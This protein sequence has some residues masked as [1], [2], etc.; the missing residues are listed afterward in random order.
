MEGWKEGRKE[1]RKDIGKEGEYDFDFYTTT[2][3]FLIDVPLRVVHRVIGGGETCSLGNDVF[4]GLKHT[5]LPFS[6]I[7]TGDIAALLFPTLSAQSHFI[8]LPPNT[9]MHSFLLYFW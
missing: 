6:I 2:E 7:M 5:C 4:W 8:P 1:E 3:D 9:Y